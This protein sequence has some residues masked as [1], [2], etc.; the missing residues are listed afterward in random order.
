MFGYVVC[1]DLRVNEVMMANV[2]EISEQL[3]EL[4]GDAIGDTLYSERWVLKVLMKL[5]K[6]I[7]SEEGFSKDLEE[8][9]CCLWDMSAERDVSLFIEK[10]GI[11]DLAIST[12]I[13][14]D[15]PRLI[16]MMI[17]IMG[18]MCCVEPIREN[19][20][21]REDIMQI[22]LN[23]LSYPDAP[24]L[25]QVMRILQLFAFKI[26]NSESDDH[27]I[28]NKNVKMETP[29]LDDH[30]FDLQA[31]ASSSEMVGIAA[32]DGNSER[33]SDDV[34]LLG[35]WCKQ[36][37]NVNSWLPQIN[38]ILRST[39]NIELIESSWLLLET[40][41]YVTTNSTSLL[42]RMA[43]SNLFQSL[44]ESF[45]E[46]F[47][48][49]VNHED[50]DIGVNSK[51]EKSIKVWTTVLYSFILH[52][53]CVH[54]LS[55]FKENVIKCIFQILFVIEMLPRDH[56][57][58]NLQNQLI[59]I[60]FSTLQTEPT[61]LATIL[62]SV[63][64]NSTSLRNVLK[65]SRNMRHDDDD[66]EDNADFEREAINCFKGYLE[67]M[68]DCVSISPEQEKNDKISALRGIISKNIK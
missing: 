40:L 6:I 10:H 44:F 35:L 4:K 66:D 5:H 22:L 27:S 50:L 45:E 61:L 21:Q 54:F 32:C 34:A 62:H 38:F 18:N 37:L 51:Y 1:F 57:S 26:A 41:C 55:E 48:S 47:Q 56:D 2:E 43:G 30:V 8:D 65:V 17:G 13:K 29:V 19:C 20:E 39:K 7:S 53:E 68:L 15:S 58:L 42:C 64:Q 31:N 60:L 3:A 67:K 46:F 28:K 59:S 14:T 33:C 36:F 52:E 11:L 63:I 49:L 23:L 25:I 9:L 16:E 24:T 12:V